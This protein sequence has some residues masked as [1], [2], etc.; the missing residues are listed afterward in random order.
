MPDDCKME[1]AEVEWKDIEAW[2]ESRTE[3]SECSLPWGCADGVSSPHTPG[4]REMS[5]YDCLMLLDQ[6]PPPPQH[7]RL[8]TS[9]PQLATHRTPPSIPSR[10]GT[11]T[12]RL[13]S[14]GNVRAPP[15]QTRLV[16]P[17]PRRSRFGLGQWAGGLGPPW[18]AGG[19][20]G[21]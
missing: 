17:H 6:T 2:Y 5:W 12:C 4:G 18:G 13:P 14:S 11:P 19:W 20:R 7:S 15:R 21:E 16:C 1:D 9:I 8:H 10:M 3:E